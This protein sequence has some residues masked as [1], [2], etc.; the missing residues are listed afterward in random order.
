MTSFKTVL[1]L[2]DIHLIAAIK[3]AENYENLSTGFKDAFAE[4]NKLIANPVVSIFEEDYEVVF[5]LCSD[6]KVKFQ[7]WLHNHFSYASDLDAFASSGAKC[8][9]LKSCMCVVQYL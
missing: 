7:L 1:K 6:Y 2:L 9:S 4:I 5:Y 8:S 3:A